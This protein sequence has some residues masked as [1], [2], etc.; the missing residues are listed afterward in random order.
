MIIQSPKGFESLVLGLASGVEGEG[1]RV[2]DG[3]AKG[4]IT[5]E[6]L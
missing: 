5:V 4:Q 1:C 3:G 2:E 6:Q